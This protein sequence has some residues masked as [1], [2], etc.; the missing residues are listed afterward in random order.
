[1]PAQNKN[2]GGS[3]NADQ[4][5]KALFFLFNLLLIAFLL[6]FIFNLPFKRYFS[7]KRKNKKIS[8]G[9]QKF[10]KKY[11]LKSPV[12]NTA[13]LGISVVAAHIYMASMMISKSVF[14][15]DLEKSLFMNFF[16]ISII[17]S[18]LSLLFLYYWEKHRVHIKYI[19]FIF[20]REELRKRIFNIKVGRIRN[21][22][23]ISA[24]MTTLLPLTLVVFYLFLNITQLSELHIDKFSE[25][26]KK[27]LYGDYL[28]YR[29][30]F[31]SQDMETT[32]Q[33]IANK[34]FFYFNAINS[35]LMFGGIF[36]SVFIAFIYILFL[37]KWTTQD[38]VFPVKE[39]L[40]NMKETGSGKMNNFGIV[41][42]NDEI[43]ELTEGYN[44][45]TQQLGD[46]IQNISKMTDAYSHFVPRQFLDF[47]GKKS[48][49]EIKL[50]D[51]VEKEMTVLFSDI[52]SF[53]EISEQMTPKENFDFLNYYLGYMEPVIR[54]NNGFIDKY[55]GDSIMA[56]FSESPENAINA[57]IEMRIKLSQFNQVMDQFGKPS[58]KS[59]IGIHSGKLML[60]VVGGEGRMDG[61]VISDAVNLTA[62]LEGLTKVYG[63]SIIISQDTLIGL[64]D[65][66]HYH[67]RF[68][69]IVK[70]KGKK[71]AVYIFEIIDGDPEDVKQLKIKTKEIFSAGINAYKMQN[72][73]DAFKLF[74]N[75]YDINKED[76]TAELYIQ[77]CDNFIKHGVPKDWDG[78]QTIRWN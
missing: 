40:L 67:Y 31:G 51:Q 50:G 43:G 64:N 65:P 68:L 37:V 24:A 30:Q 21:R 25:D 26:Q 1:V 15:D 39:L 58:I 22:M 72:F 36:S 20:S 46:Y 7:R 19:D 76:K 4:I 55:I 47:L 69:D 41:R 73:K 71:E 27:I 52:R 63:S 61:T 60:G 17:A 57:A 75:V 29:D 3:N 6:G 34:W 28:I 23:W 45:M 53:T 38:I 2:Q 12:I 66:A 14:T 62:R 35:L 77:R 10:C 78:I 49:V 5:R 8:P 42:T 9:L 44:D 56:L 32:F 16:Y 33:N 18:V 48:F 11:I 13:I 59:G 70:V 54:N 74:S